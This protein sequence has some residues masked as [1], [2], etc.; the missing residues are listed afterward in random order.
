[1]GG[2]AAVVDTEH[3]F[4]ADWAEESGV[5]VDQLIIKRPE[6]GEEGVDIAE[7]LTRGGLDFLMFDSIAATLPQDE[8]GKRL[9]KEKMQPGRQA[10]LMSAACRR[11]TA[12]NDHTAF[13]WIN[14]TRQKIGITFGSP[15]TTS[16]GKAMGF[17]ASF[18]IRMQMIRNETRERHVHNGYKMVPIKEKIAQQFKAEVTKSKLSKPFRDIFFDWDLTKGEMNIPMFLVAQ[19]I[20]F[21]IVKVTGNTYTYG[22]NVK[23]V[24]RVN[25]I[26]KITKDPKLQAELETKVR[27]AHGLQVVGAATKRPRRVDYKSDIVLGQNYRDK[28][29]GLVGNATSVHFYKNACERVVL[30]YLHDGDIKD[31]SFDAVDLVNAETHEE[32]RSKKKGG[33]PRSMPPPR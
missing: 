5:N 27:A 18:R 1:M 21:G 13:L 26:N 19:A 28:T 17:Y 9:S 4:D 12:A 20:E 11:L 22:A 14:Q 33:P 15:E 8:Q 31:A 24:G 7:V 23:A 10:A 3:S 16:G 30:T 29:T 6:T 2:V 25:F 32:P